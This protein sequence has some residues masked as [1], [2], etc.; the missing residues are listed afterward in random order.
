LFNQLTEVINSYN[1]NAHTLRLNI[2]ENSTCG[3][4]VVYFRELN[5]SERASVWK[6]RIISDL[7]EKKYSEQQYQFI[8]EIYNNI[9]ENLYDTIK[10][11]SK[12]KREDLLNQWHEYIKTDNNYSVLVPTFY[13]LTDNIIIKKNEKQQY[14]Y[15]PICDCKW[16][17][18]CDCRSIPCLIMNAGCGFIGFEYCTKLCSGS[19]H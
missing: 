1:Q 10:I 13:R 12:A 7:K 17:G 18:T 8:T 9:D 2:T 15:V 19:Q 16:G 14:P 4:V 6:D 11:E 5:P 3:E